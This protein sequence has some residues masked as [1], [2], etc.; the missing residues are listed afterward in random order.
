MKQVI[1]KPQNTYGPLIIRVLLGLV[2]I[3]H[4][5][6]KLFGWFGGYGFRNTMGYFT[7]TLGLPWIVGF[8][9]IVTE[10][11]GALSLV[12]GLAARIWSIAISILVVGI[13]ITAHSDYFFMNWMGNQ[14]GEGFEYFLLMLGMS[15]SLVVTGAG[16]FSLD[17][18][19]SKKMLARDNAQYIPKNREVRTGAVL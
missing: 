16:K 14:K 6:Q 13:V 17:A 9:V 19:I 18:L 11:F 4:G 8:L 1:F 7:E 5:S 3:A 2:L 15:V 12:L 10:F